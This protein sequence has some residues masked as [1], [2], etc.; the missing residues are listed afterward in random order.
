METVATTLARDG[1]S[2]PKYTDAAP[3]PAYEYGQILIRCTPISGNRFRGA[4]AEA[5]HGS[6]RDPFRECGETR[7]RA[8]HPRKP[9]DAR[10]AHHRNHAR[11][12]GRVRLQRRWP[13][14]SL[15]HQRGGRALAG[16]GVEGSQPP[17]PDR[18]I[19]V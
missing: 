5:W 9:P 2:V 3:R 6:A 19:V 16:E 10:E 12:S 17:L 4:F 13:A 1:T 14:R 7:R 11:G 18:K 15:L 8:V